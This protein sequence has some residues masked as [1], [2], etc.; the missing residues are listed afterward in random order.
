VHHRARLDELH[1]NPRSE[2][3]TRRLPLCN[4]REH[5]LL[6]NVRWMGVVEFMVFRL[7]IDRITHCTTALV[8]TSCIR[9]RDQKSSFA[10]SLCAMIGST[11]PWP[12]FERSTPLSSW[13]SGCRDRTDH[14]VHHCSRLEELH[15][16]PRSEVV[17]RR[18]SPCNDREQALSANLRR[19]SVVESMVFGVAD[20]EP[21]THCTPL[22]LSAS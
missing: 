11:L 8:S 2:V 9:I 7:H 15:P 13:C 22:L 3:V 12:T 10:D 6:N 21:I 14:T 4:D 5:A 17:V 19:M 18:R 20:L 1:P 16:N